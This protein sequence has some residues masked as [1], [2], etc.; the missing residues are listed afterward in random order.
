MLQNTIIQDVLSGMLKVKT[1]FIIGESYELVAMHLYIFSATFIRTLRNYLLYCWQCEMSLPP[2]SL[3]L[4]V[5]FNIQTKLFC[6]RY[7]TR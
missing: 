7:E 1:K 5:L 3:F 6:Y 4:M 2:I